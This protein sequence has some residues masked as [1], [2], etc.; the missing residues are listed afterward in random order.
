[1][2]RLSSKILTALRHPRRVGPALLRRLFPRHPRYGYPWIQLPDGSV[3]FRESGFVAADSPAVLLARHNYESLYIRRFLE[4]LFAERSLEVGCGYGRLSPVLAAFS[5]EHIAIDINSGALALARVTYPQ[6]T[7]AEHSALAL[8]FPNGHFDLL[9]TWTV[10]QHIPPDRIRQAC[11]E[12]LRVLAPGG[13][14]LMCEETR[15][16]ETASPR[17]HTWHRRVEDYQE[18]LSPLTLCASSYIDEIDKLPGRIE[19]PGRVM[20]FRSPNIS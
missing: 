3:T 18:L 20:L 1:M 6:L 7:F 17:A 12:L 2:T 15:Y 16:P 13:H 14:L 19:S 8:P 4:G 5:K 10:V 11:S 9:T